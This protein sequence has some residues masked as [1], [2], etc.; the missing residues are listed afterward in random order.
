MIDKTKEIE[1]L[2]DRAAKSEKSEDAMRFTQAA[3]NAASAMCGV[4]AAL[5]G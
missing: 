2:I 3:C 1:T 4:N 5:K